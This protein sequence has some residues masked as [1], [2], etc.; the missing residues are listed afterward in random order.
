MDIKAEFPSIGRGRLI[1]AMQAKKI[2]GDYM[3]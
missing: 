1:H 2:D 3:Q